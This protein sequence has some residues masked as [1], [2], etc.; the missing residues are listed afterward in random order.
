MYCFL[1]YK[2]SWRRVVKV[3]R[4]KKEGLKTLK[5]YSHAYLM[6]FGA[7][8]LANDWAKFDDYNPDSTYRIDTERWGKDLIAFKEP[9]K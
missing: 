2:E 6:R 4:T 9:T 8:S 3:C 5:Y 1:V 7:E